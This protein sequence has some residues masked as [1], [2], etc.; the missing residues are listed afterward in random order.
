MNGEFGSTD[1]RRVQK[2]SSA[3]ITSS[4]IFKIRRREQAGYLGEKNKVLRS[5]HVRGQNYS[6]PQR[7]QAIV[8]TLVGEFVR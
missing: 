8:P 4:K 3:Q 5:V 6:V 1:E 2:T 7:I